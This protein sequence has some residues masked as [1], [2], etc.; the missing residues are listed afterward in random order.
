M[1][2]SCKGEC[3]VRRGKCLSCGN[4]F[5]REDHKGINSVY[6]GGSRLTTKAGDEGFTSL[7]NGE[8]CSKSDEVIWLLGN[9]DTLSS[10]VGLVPSTDVADLVQETL[11]RIL[12]TVSKAPE[13]SFVPLGEEDVLKLEQ[14]IE[15]LTEKAPPLDRFQR[16]RTQ[17]GVARTMT[18]AI[19][20]QVW[21]TFS[22]HKM[23]FSGLLGRYLNRLSDFFFACEV[24]HEAG[25]KLVK[26]DYIK[27]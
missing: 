4:N 26:G 20:R 17:Y 19:E 15:V 7:C 11:Y 18:R 5:I 25:F 21:G 23:S 22:I 2:N 27:A 6:L 10:I 13:G 16:S 1:N 12:C 9:L 24:A 8:L 14:S 3:Y